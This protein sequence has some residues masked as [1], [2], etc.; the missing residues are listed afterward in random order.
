VAVGVTY[1]RGFRAAGATGGIKA[2]GRPDVALVVADGPATAAGVFTRSRAAGAPV[3]LCRERLQAGGT[4]RA[5]VV[6]SGNANVATGA[7]GR[8]DA[9]HMAALV[10]ELTGVGDDVL[11]CS[12]GVIGVSL[13]MDRVEHGIRAAAANLSPGGGHDA[14]VAICTTDSHPKLATRSFAIGGREVRIGGIAKGA[15]MIRPDLGTMIAVITTDADIPAGRLQPLL[16][17]AA[18]DSFNRITV[19]GCQSTSDSVIVLA[20]G[21]SGV[22]I[23]DGPWAEAF[24]LALRDVCLDL[25]L[26][27]VADGEGARRIARYEV[28]G[29]R[30]YD[31]ADRAARHV[32]EDQLVRCALYGADPNWGRIVAALGVCGVDLDTDRVGID[33]GGVPLVRDG[34]AVQGAAAAAGVA[35]QARRVDV[36]IDLGAGPAAAIIYGSDLSTEYVLNNSE[37]TT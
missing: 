17:A 22:E 10:G 14:A 1:P 7:Q 34:I 32:A 37:Y 16:A 3:L 31:D 2:S 6:S 11:V 19:D 23:E 29:A 35:A 13:P 15:G 9:E 24:A 28:V 33:L 27:I 36:R 4:A 5:V 8:A 20:S 25:A 21:A 26:E 18:A 30:S 12:T